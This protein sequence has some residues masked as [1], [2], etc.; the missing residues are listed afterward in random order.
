[1]ITGS[2]MSHEQ[3][4]SQAN[5]ICS[6]V[7]SQAPS[8]TIHC[9]KL[10]NNDDLLREAVFNDDVEGAKQALIGGANV[11][12]RASSPL[13][14][15]LTL[16]PEEVVDEIRKGE[17]STLLM[18]AASRGNQNMI[19]LLLKKGASKNAKGDF[20]LDG[21]GTCHSK[22]FIQFGSVTALHIASYK[23]D[24]ATVD[25]LLRA[26]AKADLQDVN[27]RTPLFWAV[28]TRETAVVLRLLKSRCGINVEDKRK[29]VPL[30]VAADRGYKEIY[31]ALKKAGA[32]GDY[33]L[34]SQSRE[35]P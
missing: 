27:G 31:D 25:R 3:I 19:E 20:L 1:M 26:K 7:H 14:K 5:S 17:P 24:V 16:L 33:L 22:S 15:E 28:L 23:G 34:K 30:K 32:K 2:L 21:S 10:M 8:S 35:N 6:I 18:F 11:N 29:V 4:G 12:L 13:I 9:H